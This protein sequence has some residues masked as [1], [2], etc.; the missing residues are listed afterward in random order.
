[1]SIGVD[2]Q[3]VLAFFEMNIARASRISGLVLV[4]LT[5]IVAMN[6]FTVLS[7]SVAFFLSIWLGT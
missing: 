5:L 2:P 7:A 6:I 4:V 3:F 1:M